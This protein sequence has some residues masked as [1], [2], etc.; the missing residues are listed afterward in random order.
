MKIQRTVKDIQRIA[1]LQKELLRA[2]VDAVDCNS[3][4]GGIIVYS[5]CSISLEE[6]EQVEAPLPLAFPLFSDLNHVVI[7]GDR[8]YIEQALCEGDQ[9][10]PGG[11]QTGLHSPLRQEV[12]LFALSLF[13]NLFN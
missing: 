11:G 5:T 3:P 13:G 9:H 1:H 8:L 2:A 6:N 4:S 12:G 7:V 10:R